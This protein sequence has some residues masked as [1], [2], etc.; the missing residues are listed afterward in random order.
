M[1]GCDVAVGSS[2]VQA[3]TTVAAAAITA[4]ETDARKAKRPTDWECRVSICIRIAAIFR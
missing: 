4:T 1:V 2:L 3:K